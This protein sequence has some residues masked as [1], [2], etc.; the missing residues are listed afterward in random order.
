[1]VIFQESQKILTCDIESMKQKLL[2]EKNF[3]DSFNCSLP[4]DISK[5]QNEL[6]SAESLFNSAV[7]SHEKLYVQ[8]LK[9]KDA[10]VF[11]KVSFETKFLVNLFVNLNCESYI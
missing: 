5:K 11:S 8:I 6:K 4:S 7:V 2:N 3:Y 10:F 1:M 9:F